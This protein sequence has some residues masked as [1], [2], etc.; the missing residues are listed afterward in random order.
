[1][2][3]FP[4]PEGFKL[5]PEGHYEFR[6][7]KEPELQKFSYTD[8]EGNSKDGRRLKIFAVGL[9]PQG[10]FLI[11]DMIAVFE[12]RYR[13]LCDALKV[14]HGKDISITGAVFEADVKHE[15]SKKDPNKVFPRLANI[16]AKDGDDI[17]F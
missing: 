6:I 12:P 1:M 5:I 8:K 3:Y 13:E 11:T 4:E 16:T 15:A 10:E 14:E 17:P 7:N 9:N 2:T